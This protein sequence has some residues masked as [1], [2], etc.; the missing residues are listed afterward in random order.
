VRESESRDGATAVL[1]GGG[2]DACSVF[3]LAE[4][5]GLRI[6]GVSKWSQK[7]TNSFLIHFLHTIMLI[8]KVVFI[9]LNFLKRGWWGKLRHLTALSPPILKQYLIQVS[10]SLSLSLSRVR[11][12]DSESQRESER[13]RERQQASEAESE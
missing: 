7:N 2:T 12:K 11:R 4:L 6:T 9:Y 3:Y 1:H 13:A 5:L 10:L 8:G